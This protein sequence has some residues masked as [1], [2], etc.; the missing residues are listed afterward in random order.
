MPIT[1]VAAVVLAQS[2]LIVGLV[3]QSARRRRAE[4]KLRA[5]QADLH[6]T[7]ARLLGAAEAER[8]RIARELHDDI[9]QRLAVLTMELDGLGGRGPALAAA[10]L[11]IRIRALSN[12]SLALAKDV[13][14][15]SRTLHTSDLEYLGLGPAAAAFCREVSQ[16]QSVEVD[17]SASDIPDGVPRDVAVCV[18]RVLQEGV[19][20]A[21]KHA[22]ARPSHG[23][24][25]GRRG[26]DSTRDC[27]TMGSAS[28]RGR[29]AAPGWV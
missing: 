9:G 26:R 5:S 17:F 15:T 4:T 14:L 24:A 28:I 16:Q 2:A 23:C 7:Y 27:P 11:R 13:Q 6:V 19:Y 12:R 8:F 21:G 29:S 3:I 10:D 20:N 1:V 18:F 25:A 22:R